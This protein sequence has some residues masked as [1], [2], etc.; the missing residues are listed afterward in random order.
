MENELMRV[1]Q[2]KH[3]RSKWNWI[4]ICCPITVG[5]EGKTKEFEKDTIPR[6]GVLWAREERFFQNRWTEKKN[7]PEICYRM[8]VL[9]VPEKGKISPHT[10][11]IYIEN[12]IKYIYNPQLR[13]LRLLI[14][15][16]F[17]VNW[18][19]LFLIF[20]FTDTSKTWLFLLPDVRY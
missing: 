14:D 1:S 20:I 15:W 2:Y 5:S 13:F 16:N 3:T 4:E 17:F 10:L 7:I 19:F 6:T 9:R 12:F 18:F 11:L 8:R